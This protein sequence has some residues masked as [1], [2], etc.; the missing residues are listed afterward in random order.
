M[1]EKKLPEITWKLARRYEKIFKGTA[2]TYIT[3]SKYPWQ[4]NYFAILD[5]KHGQSIA[6]IKQGA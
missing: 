6:T 5:N 3:I 2:H 4:L 1:K